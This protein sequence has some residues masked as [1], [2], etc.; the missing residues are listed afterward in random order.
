MTGWTDARGQATSEY[1][2]LVALIAVVLALAAGITSG[3]V[4]GH[5]LAGLQRGLCRVVGTTCPRSQPPDADLA[6]CPIER[7]TNGESLGGAF[8]VVKL[9]EGGTLT[10]ARRSDGRVVVTLG[11][12]TTAGG[13]VGLGFEL[14]VGAQRG[15]KATAGIGTSISSGRS[16]TLPNAAAARAFV[17]RYGSKATIGGKAVDVVRS[18][19][20]VLCDAIGWHP[21]AELPPPDETYLG[22]SAAATLTG[23]VG[24]A[25]LHA[26]DASVLG[27]RFRRDGAS[28]WFTQLDAAAG[29]GLALGAASLGGS[30]LRQSVVAFTLDARSRPAELAIHTVVRIGGAAAARSERGRT[31]A[32][33]G[34]GSA[35]VTEIDATLD[36]HDAGN[37][38]AAA[39]FATALRDPLATVA[40]RHRAAAVGKRIARTGVIDRRTYALSSS[41]FSL[42]ARLALGAQLGGGFERTR[43]GMRL[44]TAETRLPGL[45]FLPRDDCRAA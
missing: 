11:D 30:S 39:A 29:A 42:G 14:G 5:V 25:S 44:L 3:G 16:W 41:A 40:L 4:G 32:S 6:P 21:H 1:V 28:T 37:R 19:C 2:A 23:S 15:G 12:A 20:S 9:G 18:G 27:V 17:D 22:R 38:A 45:P 10:A 43:E 36:L 31:T 7:T 13:E 34:T 26:A 33:L 8:E 35:R 24:P